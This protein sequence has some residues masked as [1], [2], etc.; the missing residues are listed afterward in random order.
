MPSMARAGSESQANILQ[1]PESLFTFTFTVC[2]QQLMAGSF[3]LRNVTLKRTDSHDG[4]ITLHNTSRLWGSLTSSRR[5]RYAW[6]WF[7]A[8]RRRK[9]AAAPTS[10]WQ[11][12]GHV[13]SHV[14]RRSKHEVP[15]VAGECS[16]S[17]QRKPVSPVTL[18]CVPFL[19]EQSIVHS[20]AGRRLWR[21]FTDSCLTPALFSSP[22]IVT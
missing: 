18:L 2:V 20:T 22:I 5:R 14:N 6:A 19:T 7:L 9:T 8:G 15:S 17:P 12:S 1:K 10:Q 3:V 4:A 11:L 16:S 13:T 21:I